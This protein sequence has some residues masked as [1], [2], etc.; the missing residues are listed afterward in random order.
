M[1]NYS[2]YD[3][4]TSSCK[5]FPYISLLS[6]PKAKIKTFSTHKNILSLIVLGR[7]SLQLNITNYRKSL[8][9]KEL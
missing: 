2:K 1:E 6:Q 9:I 3:E 8:I 5:Y 4:S 7:P